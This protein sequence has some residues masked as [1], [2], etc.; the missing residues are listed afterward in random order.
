MLIY[1]PA[2]D[3]YHCAFRALLIIETLGS[4]EI[5]K[6]RILDFYLVF[7]AEL[8]IVRLPR[9][10]AQEKKR[11][12]TFA[13]D[14]HGPVNNALTFRDIE[15]IQRA[16]MS[17]LAASN[18]IDEKQFELGYAK[19]TGKLIPIELIELIN[20]SKNRN[21]TMSKYILDEFSKIPLRG[22]DGLKD[23]TKLMEYRY[24][25]T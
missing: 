3:A 10:H 14:Y 20:I 25:V 16:A 2:Y 5:D 13:N 12:A 1:H 18:L 24:D 19:R 15:P 4:V 7:P 17:A 9:E 6:F 11:A 23:R 21:D 22:I 8:K